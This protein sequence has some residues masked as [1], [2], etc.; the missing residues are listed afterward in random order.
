MQKTVKFV[1]VGLSFFLASCGAKTSDANNTI[2]E[3]KTQ[4]EDLKKQ[5]QKLSGDIAALEAE[6]VKLD[7]SSK[8]EKTK[9]VSVAPVTPQN[10]THYIELQGT[11]DAEDISYVAPRN[12][13]GGLVKQIFIKKGDNVKKGQQI[14]KL[15]DAVYLT[16]LKQDQS[17]LAFAEDLYR[18]QKNLWDQ[19]I[20][21][22]IQLVQAKQNVD[23]IEDQIAT[24][25]EQWSMTNIYAG[26]SGIADEVNVRV[27][28]LFTG[29]LGQ[30]AQ[31]KIVNTSRLKVRALVPE[32]YLDRVK[33]G[34][35]LIVTLPDAGKTFNTTISLAGLSIDPNN[36]SFYIEGKL[37]SDKDL[38]PNQVALVKIQDYAATNAI[39]IPVN[40]LQTDEKGKFVLVAATENGK[41]T[42]RK[43]QV[44]IGQ[45]YAD[46]IEIKTGLQAGD[47]LITTGVQGLYDG[48][49]I[50]LATN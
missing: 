11:I 16:N 49:L 46:Q 2:A 36:R 18:R 37:P 42:A 34:G 23:Q 13:Q 6:I 32:N 31:I 44:T 38:R 41:L 50:T 20:G 21:T 45:F 48:Q 40:T 7:P 47:Q 12:G 30:T 1:L 26:V 43:K 39:S 19:Q 4:L 35:N 33:T 10:F 24:I 17:Q 29:F 3:K 22:E 9:L 8:T 15:D 5:Q 25:N 27:G 14:L 28:E